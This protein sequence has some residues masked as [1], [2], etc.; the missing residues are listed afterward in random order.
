MLSFLYVHS[1]KVGAV[2][3]T[4]QVSAVDL[5]NG[6]MYLAAVVGSDLPCIPIMK[7]L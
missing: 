1:L 4:L 5:L 7:T 3:M 2:L 6:V